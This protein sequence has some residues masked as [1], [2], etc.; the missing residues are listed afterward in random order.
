MNHLELT[1]LVCSGSL[2]RDHSD[3]STLA[4]GRVIRFPVRK[5]VASVLLCFLLV[6][7]LALIRRIV[8]VSDHTQFVVLFVHAPINLACACVKNRA[9]ACVKDRVGA[10]VTDRAYACVKNR[11]YACVK[12]RAYACVT[13]CV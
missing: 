13:K 9:F 1:G 7:V 3:C 12:N 11:A 4:E 5:S 6:W 10:C 2:S 8:W